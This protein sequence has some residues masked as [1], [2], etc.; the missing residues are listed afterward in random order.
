MQTSRHETDGAACDG[1]SGQVRRLR[2]EG[3]LRAIPA[4]SLRIKRLHR[5]ALLRVAGMST[6]P[7]FAVKTIGNARLRA[8]TIRH[9][10]EGRRNRT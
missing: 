1:F 8:V 10:H 7:T 5:Q 3:K 6:T 9:R 4:F 2:K